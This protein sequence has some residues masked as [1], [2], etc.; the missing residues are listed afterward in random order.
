MKDL[1]KVN[2]LTVHFDIR[3]GFL[4]RES[5][6][7]KAVNG[8]SFDI[9]TKETLGLVGESGSGKSTV[10]KALLR[11]VDVTS[12]SIELAGTPVQHLEGRMLDFRRDLQVVFQ[13]PYSS[14]NPSMIVSDIVGEPLSIHFGLHGKERDKR[15]AELLEQVGLGAYLLERYPAE[16]SGGQRQRIAIARAL[17]LSPRLI[18]CDEPVSALDVSTQSQVINLLESLQEQFGISYL[19]IAHDLAVVRHISDRI[20]VM[21]LGQ[22]MELGPAE[23][24]YEAPHH[25]YTRMLLAAIP[26]VNPIEQKQRKAERRL[27]PVTELPAPTNL[28]TGCPFHTRCPDAMEVCTSI[29]PQRVPISTGGWVACHLYD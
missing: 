15:V 10:G 20:G 23:R 2:D 21:Y 26:V 24:I 18:V 11:L 22:L 5:Y 16:F 1:L 4:G 13:D 19:F 28:P 3:R 14:L 25:P 9:G 6:T 29:R 17:A 27:I 12:G 8:V 7:V